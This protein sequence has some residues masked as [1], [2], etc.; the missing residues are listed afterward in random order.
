MVCRSINCLCGCSAAQSLGFCADQLIAFNYITNFHAF[1]PAIEG[2]VA[3]VE[4]PD[5]F[6]AKIVDR[7]AEFVR[8][9]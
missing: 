3:G 7:D 8:I 5:R 2:I 4:L 1:V 6:F 9:G